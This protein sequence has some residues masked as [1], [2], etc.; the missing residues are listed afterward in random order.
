MS[1]HNEPWE[2]VDDSQNTGTLV[3]KFFAIKDNTGENIIRVNGGSCDEQRVN[4]LVSCVNAC[5]GM[6]DKDL[7]EVIK[8]GNVGR[9]I[10]LT[11]DLIKKHESEISALTESGME[12]SDC[13]L[14]EVGRNEVLS[15]Q[16]TEA[17]ELLDLA[18]KTMGWNK[19]VE[20]FL[21]KHKHKDY[22]D[23]ATSQ[24]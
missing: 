17:V 8:I 15:K 6:S 3:L 5:A 13:F 21:I 9:M 11:A 4:R 23:N 20:D 22:S 1:E 16:F 24:P 14:A 19:E 10:D 12:A 2:A 7:E 18:M